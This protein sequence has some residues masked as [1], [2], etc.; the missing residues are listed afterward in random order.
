MDNTRRSFPEAVL[1]NYLHRYFSEIYFNYRGFEWNRSPKGSLMEYDIFIPIL[2][3]ALE[4]DGKYFHTAEKYEN[5]ITKTMLAE[6]HNITL[7]RVHEK[8]NVEIPG[9]V[10]TIE[11]NYT[12]GDFQDMLN[13][14]AE[15]INNRYNFG[16]E[17][18]NVVDTNELMKNTRKE[19]KTTNNR[20]SFFCN[21]LKDYFKETGETSINSRTIYHYSDERMP[22]NLGDRYQKLREDMFHG[23]LSQ[24]Q[25]DKIAAIYPPFIEEVNKSEL[26]RKDDKWEEWFKGYSEYFAKYGNK[27][28]SSIPEGTF[29]GYTAREILYIA[30]KQRTSLQ[31]NPLQD[32]IEKIKSVNPNF[33]TDARYAHFDHMLDTYKRYIDIT[34]SSDIDRSLVFHG[35][36]LGPWVVQQLRELVPLFH[37][38][39][40]GN[41]SNEI[42]KYKISQ[43]LSTVPEKEKFFMSPTEKRWYTQFEKF[44]SYKKNPSLLSEKDRQAAVKWAIMQRKYYSDGK[45]PKDDYR[46]KSLISVDKDF[47]EKSETQKKNEKL[48]DQWNIKFQKYLEWCKTNHTFM[49]PASE[50]D[51]F[52]FVNDVKNPRLTE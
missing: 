4:Y 49:V 50:K 33:F 18:I 46:Y 23:N 40:T 12:I 44:K 37:D 29:N 38:Y 15:W 9:Y 35:E 28:F 22:V 10:L 43:I 32:R 31:A 13:L 20:V 5:D 30:S 21:L 26:S 42:Q 25:I 47:F 39:Q 48:D 7:L 34:G 3:L 6:E 17:A 45:I 16:I 11:N 27:S 52:G 2:D 19:L 14:V 1:G 36:K 8:S 24:E 41:L 51:I